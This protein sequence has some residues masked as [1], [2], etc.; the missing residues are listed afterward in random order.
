MA[1]SND[2]F[3]LSGKVVVLI[4]GA[5]LLGKRFGHALASRG[6]CLAIVDRDGDG[7]VAVSKAIASCSNALVR[8]YKADVSQYHELTALHEVIRSD[9][10]EVDILINNAAAKS[11]NFFESFEKFPLADWEYVMRINTTGVMLGCQEFGTAMA[12]RGAG[13]IIN[14]LSIY[15]IVAPDQRIYEGATYEGKSINTPAVYSTSKAAVWGLTRYLATYWG[16]KGVRVNAITPGGVFSG[17]NE[18]FV[19]QYSTRVPL[20][21]M[22]NIDE[23]SGAVLFLASD[24]SSYITGQNIIVDGGLTIW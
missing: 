21:R 6:A 23:I 2:N 16:S 14:I 1:H 5:G 10:G 12:M 24:A 3:E 17:Q 22:A 20:G 8:P 4:G 9:L 18:A 7:A 15:G 13:S 19:K 11:P